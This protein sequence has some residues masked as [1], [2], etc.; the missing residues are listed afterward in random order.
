[1]SIPVP[2]LTALVSGLPTETRQKMD[3]AW[4]SQEEFDR[5]V[6]QAITALEVE[7]AAIDVSGGG[8]ELSDA[9]PQDVGTASAGTGTKASR[10]DHVHALGAA[11][12]ALIDEAMTNGQTLA[13]SRGWALP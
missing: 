13:M 8:V 5:R 1:M 10:D 3:A 4:R 7:I 2:S 12:L 9:T 11:V 6:S